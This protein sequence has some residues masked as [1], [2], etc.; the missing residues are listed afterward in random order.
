MAH[1][2]QRCER[3]KPCGTPGPSKVRKPSLCGDVTRH[4]HLIGKQLS[5]ESG[6]NK[7]DGILKLFEVTRSMSLDCFKLMQGYLK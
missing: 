2:L 7:Q 4:D 6:Y 5:N 3:W 1:K